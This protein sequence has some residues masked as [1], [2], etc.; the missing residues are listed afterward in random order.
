MA[1]IVRVERRFPH[2]SMH[3]GLGAQPPVCMVSG[4]LERR[5]LDPCDIPDRQVEDLGI[6]GPPFAPAQVLRIPTKLRLTPSVRDRFPANY[7]IVLAASSQI[8]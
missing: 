6:E 8:T 3:A 2:E 1:P 7:G 4:E 5:A